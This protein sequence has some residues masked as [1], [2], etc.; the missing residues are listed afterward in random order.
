MAAIVNC[1]LFNWVPFNQS[2]V[3]NDILNKKN[4]I[5]FVLGVLLNRA[6]TSTQLHPPPLSSIHLHPAHFNLHPALCNTIN[7]IRTKIL[8]VIGQFPQI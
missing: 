5:N 8:H 7:V 1:L 3:T 6:P 2:F 4:M